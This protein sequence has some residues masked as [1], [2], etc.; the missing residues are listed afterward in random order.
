MR[1]KITHFSALLPNHNPARAHPVLRASARPQSGASSPASPRFCPTTVR[2]HE[3]TR[4]STLLP[5]HSPAA[6][7]H[8]LPRASAR[9]QSGS[10]NSPT[11]P[12]FCPT[13]VRQHELTHFPALLPDHSPAART[14][15]LPRASAGPQSG[16]WATPLSVLLPDRDPS[17]RKMCWTVVQHEQL[18]DADHRL[19]G[20]QHSTSSPASPRFCRTT[21][22]QHELTRFS[23]LLPD[24]SPAVGPRP[25]QCSCPTAIHLSARCA[26]LWSSTSN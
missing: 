3:L 26:G 9:P 23:A 22:R 5:D 6:R 4:F 19:A 11:S 20:P 14:H 1:H 15:P 18:K 12:R 16:S 17:L 24:H 2:Q 25:S 13:T 8:P 7:T 10:T 21:V